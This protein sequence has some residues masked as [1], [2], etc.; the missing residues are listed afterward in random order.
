[1]YV[2]RNG[3]LAPS[4]LVF[5]AFAAIMEA[6]YA[7]RV[8]GFTPIGTLDDL[9]FFDRQRM[10][11]AKNVFEKWTCANGECTTKRSKDAGSRNSGA[12]SA[13][14]DAGARRVGR[15][16]A[17]A[18]ASQTRSYIFLNVFRGR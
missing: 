16:Q 18:D 4:A 14:E 12:I 8:P 9:A 6:I 3:V 15:R 13:T 17:R 10:E 7:Q 2:F 1:M 5:D 11:F